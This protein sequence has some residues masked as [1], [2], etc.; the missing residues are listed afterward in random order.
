MKRCHQPAA[1][2][3]PTLVL[4][5]ASGCKKQPSD[6]DAIR[7]GITQHLTA[8]NTLNLSAM[9]MDVT[10]VAI[11]GTSAQ[12]QVTFH[13]KTGAPP[14]AG[15]QVSYQLEKRDSAW[16]VVKTQGVG[17]GIEHPPAGANPHTQAGAGAVHGS[18]PNFQE[19][20]GPQKPANGTA[21]PPGHP[22]VDSTPKTPQ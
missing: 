16:V 20:L 21:L 17:G 15:M 9:D 7:A 2:I 11:N 14:G 8:L 22:P 10:N 18:L 12:A 19:I 13:P 3:L 6:A 5:F 4:L 1:L